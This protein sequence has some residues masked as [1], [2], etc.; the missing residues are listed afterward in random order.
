LF[1]AEPFLN[2]AALV[3]IA[4]FPLFLI[5][6]WILEGG[7]YFAPMGI[8]ILVLLAVVIIRKKQLGPDRPHSDLPLQRPLSAD[9]ALHDLVKR[10]ASRLRKASPQYSFI[11]LSPTPWHRFGVDLRSFPRPDRRLPLPITYLG[12]LSIS[13]LEAYIARTLVSHRGPPWLFTAVEL[14]T[15]RLGAEQYQAQLRTATHWMVRAQRR[16]LEKYVD[17][18]S[19]WRLLVDLDADLRVARMLGADVVI[20]LAYKTELANLLASPFIP[21]VVEPALD[22]QALLPIAESY[23]AYASTVDPH[24]RDAV[25]GSLKHAE[26]SSGT[27]S[28]SVVARL[29]LLSNLPRSIAV[30]DP[31]PAISAFTDFEQLEREV[32]INEFGRQRLETAVK[33]DSS[34]WARLALIPLLRDEVD[35]N[36]DILHAKTRFDIPELLR[37]KTELAANYITNRK[38]LLSQIQKQERVPY[39]LGAFL[40]LDL[41][42]EQ[43]VVSYEM[44]AGIQLRSSDRQLRPFTLVEQLDAKV[45]TDAEFLDAVK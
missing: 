7:I 30:Q 39:L 21:E 36:G 31:R 29:A 2:P 4:E 32:A 33:V 15:G 9:L 14:A 37:N 20:S 6:L 41:I 27:G 24:W 10:V 3:L 40:A 38:F 17:L 23:A 25:S 44:A 45:I 5:L 43:W 42:D 19:A 1:V 8:Y 28:S 18:V 12:I 26:S 35:R 13:E 22:K 16:A 34:N 11:S